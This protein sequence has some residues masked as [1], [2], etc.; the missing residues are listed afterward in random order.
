[1]RRVAP[2]GA[3]GRVS[4]SMRAFNGVVDVD[5]HHLDG[6]PVDEADDEETFLLG[7]PV[8]HLVRHILE[9]RG[10]SLGLVWG[11]RVSDLTL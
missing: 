5:T 3:L 8:V 7:E 6:E 11:Q 9:H 2:S 1:M 4:R 10:N